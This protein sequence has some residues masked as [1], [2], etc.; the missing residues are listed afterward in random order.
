[1]YSVF[2][3]KMKMTTSLTTMLIDNDLVQVRS[4]K[5]GAFVQNCGAF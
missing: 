1:M 2:G 4:Q 3:I 5:L